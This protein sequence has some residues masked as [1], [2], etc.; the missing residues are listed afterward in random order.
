MEKRKSARLKD[1]YVRSRL[2]R[3]L[4]RLG[5][6]VS[7]SQQKP[8]RARRYRNNKKKVAEKRPRRKLLGVCISRGF[9]GEAE[10]ESPETP[11]AHSKYHQRSARREKSDIELVW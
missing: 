11:K 5:T 6:H 7:H 9:G 2:A 8:R 1:S 10:A 3:V 4:F